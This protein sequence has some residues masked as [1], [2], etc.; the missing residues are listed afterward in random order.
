MTKTT[1]SLPLER[2]YSILQRV[3]DGTLPIDSIDEFKD[4]LD[5]FPDNPLLHR[6]YADLLADKSH[7]DQAIDAYTRA[8]DKF[9]DNE[10]NL[11]AVVAKIL[12]WT[13]Q[14]P[15]HL[16]G[17]AFQARLYDKGG[18]HT[19]LQ[20]FW[21]RMS[22]PE[23]VVV[24]RRLVRVRLSNGEKIMAVDDPADDIYFIVSGTLAETLSPDCRSDAA[25]DGVDSEPIFLGPND[26]FGDIFPLDQP[27]RSSKD[28]VAVSEVELVR[29]SKKVLFNAC[30]KYPNIET[31]LMK[32]HKPQSGPICDRSWQTVRKTIRY[33]LP[34]KVDI[35]PS[36]DQD[37]ERDSAW[38]YLGIAVDISV[39][40]TCVDLGLTPI[41]ANQAPQKG[42]TVDLQLDLLDGTV[43]LKL[44]ATIVWLR[45]N[46]TDK[47]L[48]IMVGLRFDSL[49][50]IER[51]LLAEYCAGGIGEQ[52]LLWSLWNSMVR[53]EDPVK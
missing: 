24:M 5:V 48:A 35:K 37:E 44:S 23:L 15:E 11:Q 22:Y 8:A 32:I 26:I 4:I 42:E 39:G 25:R 17:S 45:K 33:G 52:N 30:L 20:R 21:A 12:Q 2:E 53:T 38:Q 9:I 50:P 43:K 31:L 10:M 3:L 29:I 1:L 28:I 7:L 51:E 36:Q 47:G 19:P 49:L 41:D 6:K 13:L 27:T 40:G 16:Q 46:E 14:K 18:K 34:T